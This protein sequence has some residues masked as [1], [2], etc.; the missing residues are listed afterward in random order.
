MTAR[1][2]RWGLLLATIMSASLATAKGGDS[3]LRIGAVHAPAGT[4]AR[5]RAALS[6]SL[7]RHLAD[8]GLVESLSPYTI[9]PSLTQ[10]RRYVEDSKQVKLVCMVDLAL[11]DAQG[12]VVGTVRGR[13]TTSGASPRE[14]IDA[15]AHAAV[16]RLPRAL[17]A[18]SDSQKPPTQVAAATR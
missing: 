14:T 6:A 11:S 5:A 9:S 2:A 8:A 7:Q 12:S 1:S 13:A 10:L 17:Q 16:A 15:A 18:L 4:D 3:S